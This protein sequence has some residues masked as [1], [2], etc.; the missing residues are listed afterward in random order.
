MNQL[1]MDDITTFA[2]TP[3]PPTPGAEIARTSP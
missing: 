2:P 1:V 3:A